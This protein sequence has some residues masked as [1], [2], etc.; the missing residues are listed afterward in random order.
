MNF[1]RSLRLNSFRKAIFVKDLLLANT[2]ASLR[3]IF[4][5]FQGNVVE[6]ITLN[7]IKIELENEEE[8]NIERL[9]GIPESLIRLPK[10]DMLSVTL[11]KIQFYFLILSAPFIRCS[12]VNVLR[13]SHFIYLDGGLI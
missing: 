7:A 12:K 9:D 1:L 13:I 2:C 11:Q 3:Y 8:V 10:E 4:A 5:F 6:L